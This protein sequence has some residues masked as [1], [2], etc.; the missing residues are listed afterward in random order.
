MP[1]W[2]V[3]SL[4]K[5][6]HI[7]GAGPFCPWGP[8]PQPGD[9]LIAADGGYAHLS[10]WGLMPDLV[11]G[12]FDSGPKPAHP[13]VISL[14]R[15]KDVTD[16]WAAAQLGRER[17]YSVFYIYGGLGG[18]LDHTLANIQLLCHMADAGEQG[19]LVDGQV[20][21]TAVA[22]ARCCLPP[23]LRGRVWSSYIPALGP[24]AGVANSSPC[25][26]CRSVIQLLHF[27]P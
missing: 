23:T 6:C 4:A 19:Y 1:G 18:Q 26:F 12:D 3:F 2:E 11:V 13:Q 8:Q 14:P 22:K 20:A 15:E 9:L 10:R 21:V 27:F 16:T 24:P 25:N 5:I 7:V 17:G